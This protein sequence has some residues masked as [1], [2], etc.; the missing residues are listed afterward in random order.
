VIAIVNRRNS[1]LVYKSH[2]VL[3]TS[4]GRD[5]EMSVASTKAFYA[6]NV[7]GQVLALA[8]AEALEALPREAIDREARALAALPR[9]MAE[10]LALGPAVRELAER[11][12]PRKPYWAVVGSGPGKI[13]A[14][15]IRIKLSELCY[16]SIAS[17]YLEDKK[18]IDLSSE[19]L[20]LVAANDCSPSTISDC[21]KEVSIFKAH[22]SIP[23]VIAEA[24]ETRFDPYAAGVI[25]VPR[26]DGALSYLLATIIGHL[27]G[28]HAAAS[29][30]RQADLLRSIRARTIRELTARETNGG[31]AELDPLALPEDLVS[32]IVRLEETLQEG[33]LDSG[34]RTATAVRLS[35]LLQVLLGRQPL[36]PL[37]PAP[38][39]A[40]G[41]PSLLSTAVLVLTAGINELSRPIDAI[42]HQAKTV[43]VGISRLE[44]PRAEGALWSE[45][46]NFN[47]TGELAE[48]HRAFLSALDPLVARVA[49]ATLY[50]VAGLD[51]VG[52]P[53]SGSTILAEKKT[54]TARDIASRCE[55]ERLLAGTKWGVVKSRE[56]YLGYG[57]NDGRRILILPIIGE[58]R[59]GHLLLCHLELVERGDRAAR[60]KALATRRSHLERLKI[61]VTE[62]NLS[63]D[64]ALIDRLTNDQLFLK[65]PEEAAAELVAAGP[66]S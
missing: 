12:A 3:Y 41:A 11:H 33:A 44:E 43:T 17:D 39:A 2:G 14:D 26:H 6:Q 57:Q 29:F 49:G 52:R 16:K 15:E 28:Y 51:P 60:L 55:K 23:L 8:L 45:I 31:A 21:V 66:P 27:F 34:L 65:P 18:H 4:D 10:T 9:A 63:W 47:L 24:G 54:G 56:A 35:T 1:D 48:G 64:P 36:D 19:P 22:R 42:K 25:S 13:A 30:D 5:I 20:V 7:A 32:D 58:K 38:E 62:R 40:S 37:A 61:A 46:R 50:R 53:R 59:E